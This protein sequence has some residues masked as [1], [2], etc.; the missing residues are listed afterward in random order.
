MSALLK[1]KQSPAMNSSMK[2]VTRGR[3][4]SDNHRRALSVWEEQ[5]MD[6]SYIY[7]IIFTMH[8]HVIVTSQMLSVLFYYL[9]YF[10]SALQACDCH[11]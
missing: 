1:I 4:S 3:T 10:I 5:S 8:M 2:S 11:S 6:T 7:S 9:S